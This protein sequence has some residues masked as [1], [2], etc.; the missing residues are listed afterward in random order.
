MRLFDTH[1][2]LADDR[3]DSDR[4]RL[5]SALPG[6]GVDLVL[7]CATEESDWQDVAKIAEHDYIYA[8]L[9][10]HPHN[11]EGVNK[12]YLHDLEKALSNPKCVAVG[13]IGLD[14]HYEFSPREIQKKVFREQLELAVSLD[15][16]VVIHDREAHFDMLST[17]KPFSGKLRGV[18]HCYSGSAEMAKEL[19]DMGLYIAFG[20]ALTFPS[21][22]KTRAAALTVP[23]EKLLIET[24]CPYLTP[25]PFRGKRNDPSFVRYTCE[26]LAGLLSMEPGQIADITYENGKTCFGLE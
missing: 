15:L 8:A 19:V 26:T 3:F 22:K 24:D 10:V 4:E 2:H 20:G 21:A 23:R 1:A 25:H 16:P 11:A 12:D 13:E 14:Y 18:M 5:L 7:E 17:I 6:M 9:G